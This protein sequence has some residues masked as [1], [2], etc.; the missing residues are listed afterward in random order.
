MD[1]SAS[2]PSVG[3][4]QAILTLV[5]FFL[6]SASRLFPPSSRHAQSRLI[7]SPSQ[8]SRSSSLY[9]SQSHSC[10]SRQ[11]TTP[12]PSSTSSHTSMRPQSPAT[13][14]S[15]SSPSRS[16]PC[17]SSSPP[18]RSTAA[19][20]ATASSGPAGYSRS[21]SWRSSSRS[22]VALVLTRSRECQRGVDMLTA[23]FAWAGVH[24]HLARRDR[25]LPL[26]RVL[27]R[28]QGRVLWPPAVR[29]P[30]PLLRPLRGR[31]RE[32]ECHI[33]VVNMHRQTYLSQ[34][35][36]ILSGTAFLAYFTRVAG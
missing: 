30:L 27:G 33:F 22:C 28:E 4:W 26:P 12:S 29:V 8:T 36:V 34:D 15:T 13:S 1:S 14:R 6:S 24:L 31:R 3:N 16:S 10:S 11:R 9:A 18:A 25:P 23:T 5:L 17:S 32:R 2:A 7:E 19:P 35:L 21:T 20:S